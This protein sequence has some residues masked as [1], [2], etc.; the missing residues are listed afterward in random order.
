MRF[1]LEEMAYNRDKA[2]EKIKHET[3]TYSEHLIKCIIYKNFT[4]NLWH[5]CDELADKIDTVNRIKLKLGGKFSQKFY[6]DEFFLADGDCPSDFEIT[7]KDFKRDFRFKYPDFKITPELV[8]EVSEAFNDISL[9]FSNLVCRENNKDKLW[10][11]NTL[12]DY[13][14]NKD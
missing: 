12:L 13:F 7:L 3:E 11:R 5:W 4:N 9:Y 2:I 10:F 8:S 1:K 6:E 14:E